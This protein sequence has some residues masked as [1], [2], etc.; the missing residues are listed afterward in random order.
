MFHF[1]RR[2]N[3]SSYFDMAGATCIGYRIDIWRH[4]TVIA[5]AI[6]AGSGAQVA[7]FHHCLS[8][9]TLTPQLE[10]VR[11]RVGD[12]GILDRPSIAASEWQVA[13]VLATR[14]GYTG[15]SKS[16]IGPNV[17]SA[18]TGDAQVATCRVSSLLESLSM[19]AGP[20]FLLLVHPGRGPV[21][22]H[23]TW[24]FEWQWPQKAGTSCSDFRDR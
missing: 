1:G 10:L 11:A 19:T 23:G 5:V 20:I 14:V 9:H 7:L 21:A 6:V 17:V 3:N 12:R 13:Q 18:V 24:V 8:M 22:S 15:E 4:S 2:E 16:P